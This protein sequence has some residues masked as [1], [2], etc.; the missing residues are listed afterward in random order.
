MIPDLFRAVATYGIET[1]FPII[2]VV[3]LRPLGLLYG[4]SPFAFAFSRGL[5]VRVSVAVALG[6]PIL[7]LSV[8]QFGDQFIEIDRLKLFVFSF[9]ELAI[10][11][12]LGFIA[13]IPFYIYRYA[14]SAVANYKG[15]ADGGFTD[16]SDGTIE[17]T[18]MLF[19]LIGMAAFT[20]AG[21]FWILTASLY[22]SYPIWP[23]DSAIPVFASAAPAEFAELLLSSL[24]LMFKIAA[25]LFGIL[26]F[27]DLFLATCARIA[28]R[29][30]LFQYSLWSKNLAALI[31]MPL[32]VYIIWL[33]SQD[34]SRFSFDAVGFLQGVLE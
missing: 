10:G 12:A 23:I 21:G 6:M 18:A 2:L 13:S 5:I 33:S 22:Q 34:I 25:P 1:I 19:Q 26:I 7:G 32:F 20:W 27:I 30:Q 31:A 15:E 8:A 14:G 9:K 3:M 16:P 29:F 4:F 24:V 17:S 11:F 28:P